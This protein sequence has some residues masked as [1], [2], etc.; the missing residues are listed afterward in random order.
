[1]ITRAPAERISTSFRIRLCAVG[2]VLGL[3]IAAS[4]A[5]GLGM[6]I[7]LHVG[8]FSLFQAL[9][10]VGGVHGEVSATPELI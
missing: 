5:S 6:P 10:C 3:G 9:P 1:M 4:F 7:E 2:T 8:D